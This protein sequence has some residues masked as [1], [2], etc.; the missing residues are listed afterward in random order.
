MV[1]ADNNS[2]PHSAA[3]YYGF[4]LMGLSELIDDTRIA[5]MD[6]AAIDLLLRAQGVFCD[7]FR[8]RYPGAEPKAWRMID[9]LV[10]DATPGLVP[11]YA[12]AALIDD[13]YASEADQEGVSLLYRAEKLFWPKA[14]S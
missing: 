4:F 14:G 3:D 8:L 2:P 6:P 5:G 7:E 10:G 11:R 12:V 9:P 13:A 1:P